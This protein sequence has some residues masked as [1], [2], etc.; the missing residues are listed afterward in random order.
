MARKI[1]PSNLQLNM[2]TLEKAGNRLGVFSFGIEG[3]KMG[4]SEKVRSL[5]HKILLVVRPLS[6]GIVTAHWFDLWFLS[7]PKLERGTGSNIDATLSKADVLNSLKREMLSGLRHESGTSHLGIWSAHPIVDVHYRAIK[8]FDFSILIIQ[9]Y[10]SRYFE[11]DFYVAKYPAVSNHNENPLSHFVKYGFFAL[12]NPRDGVFNVAPENDWRKRDDTLENKRSY[13]WSEAEVR[14][15]LLESDFASLLTE[16]EL[17]IQGKEDVSPSAKLETIEKS[18]INA[19]PRISI[20]IPCYKQARFISECLES[21]ALS[22]SEFHECI[23]VDD[24][25][26]DKEDLEFLNQVKPSAPHQVVRIVRQVNMGLSA[27]RNAG[28]SFAT[29]EFIKFLDCDDLLSPGSLDAQISEMSLK[30]S[31]ADIGGYCIIGPNREILIDREGPLTNIPLTQESQLDM[32]GFLSTWEQGFSIPIH[33]LL[34]RKTKVEAFNPVL[35]SKEDLRMWLE[36]GSL[37]VNFSMSPGMTALYRQ[38]AN[39]MT[40]NNRAKHGLYFLE[41]LFDFSNKHPRELT[42]ELLSNKIQ[43]INDFYSSLPSQ[44]LSEASESRRDWLD[45]LN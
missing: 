1:W 33:C 40:N 22:T 29:G 21:V 16:A 42:D 4:L 37:G 36:L 6:I 31:D 39:Q 9:K 14:P 3:E 35:R 44:A 13:L 2:E 34:I 18:E 20:I 26:S 8:I 23:I 28:L 7:N 41:A 12:N 24:G 10:S 15:L 38:H 27:A 25:N 19:N 32:S 17:I 30:Q 45:R 5:A 11:S 43:Y